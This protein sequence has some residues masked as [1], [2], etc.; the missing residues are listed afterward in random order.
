M[1]LE[2]VESTDSLEVDRVT[3]FA[4]KFSDIPKDHIIIIDVNFTPMTTG[5]ESQVTSA[6]CFSNMKSHC[7][8]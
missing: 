1:H 6:K 5:D 3:V 2:S 7:T 8:F 4:N